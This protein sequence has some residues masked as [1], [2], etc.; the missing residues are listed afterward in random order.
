MPV[1]GLPLKNHLD[2]PDALK[3]TSILSMHD[4]SDTVIPWGGG[5]AGGWEYESGKAVADSWAKVHNCELAASVPVKTPYD[6]GAKNVACQWYGKCAD[7]EYADGTVM[8]RLY[9]GHHGDWPAE[10]TDLAMWFFM[11]KWRFL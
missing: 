11:G 1:Y 4:R 10:G 3:G 6:G 8:F 2:V 5:E 9:D 7:D